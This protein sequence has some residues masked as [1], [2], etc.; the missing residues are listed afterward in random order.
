[1]LEET[2]GDV[3]EFL[4]WGVN[5]IDRVFYNIRMKLEIRRRVNSGSLFIF[6]NVISCSFIG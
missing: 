2:F 1:M 5:Y 3:R 6:L 4:A